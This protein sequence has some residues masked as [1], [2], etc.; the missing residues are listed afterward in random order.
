MYCYKKI[1]TVSI[2]V[3]QKKEYGLGILIKNIFIK[4]K[5]KKYFL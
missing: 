2:K 5:S 3:K 1:K 4:N